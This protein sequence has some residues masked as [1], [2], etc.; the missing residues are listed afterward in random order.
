MRS[1]AQPLVGRIQCV[2][3]GTIMTQLIQDQ[4]ADFIR[5]LMA[6]TPVLA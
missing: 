6:V 1:V 5:R 2:G 4:Y 3:V